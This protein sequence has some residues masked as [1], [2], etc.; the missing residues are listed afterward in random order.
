MNM[1]DETYPGLIADSLLRTCFGFV[2]Q[3]REQDGYS[4][5]RTI[6]QIPQKCHENQ[7]DDEAAGGEGR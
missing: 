1:G 3:P 2:Q 4:D 6:A 5:K 7:P